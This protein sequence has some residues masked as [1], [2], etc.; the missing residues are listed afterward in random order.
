MKLSIF[1]LHL[2][3]SAHALVEYPVAPRLYTTIHEKRLAG[4]KYYTFDA[5][6]CNKDTYDMCKN[7]HLQCIGIAEDEHTLQSF[8]SPYALIT[9]ENTTLSDIYDVPV[10]GI[11]DTHVKYG[12]H[13]SIPYYIHVYREH[14]G[15]IFF[16]YF[17]VGLAVCIVLSMLYR[18]TVPIYSI[19]INCLYKRRIMKSVIYNEENLLN[20]SCT[21]CLDDFQDDE[22]LMTL[23]ECKHT[24]HK[25][26]INSW[27]NTKQSCPNC[28]QPVV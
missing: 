19:V 16:K 24:F 12:I 28:Q 10:L 23:T 25:D 6:V 22:K 1:I 11:E 13:T 14:M 8:E 27:L 2:L 9:Y 17:M 26:C 15:L 18:C 4:P 21:I 20:S 5:Y 3:S 7:A